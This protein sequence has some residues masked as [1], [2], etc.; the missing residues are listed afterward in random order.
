MEP[1]RSNSHEPA[2]AEP[3]QVARGD[4]KRFAV[5]LGGVVLLIAAVA[6]GI[7]LFGDRLPT[8]TEERLQ[9]AVRRWN[10]GDVDSY[11]MDLEITGQRAGKVHVEVQNGVVVELQ[12]DG[13]TPAQRRTWD[14]WSVPGQFDM[15]QQGL[16]IAVDPVGNL[17]AQQ[18]TQVVVR[19]T[20]DAQLGYPLAF[21]QV[22]LGGGPEFGWKTVRFERK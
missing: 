5:F 6:V 21:S 18:G 19:A 22:T 13:Q 1:D 4:W 17:Q 10:E 2:T 20:F 11:V 3:S 8:L 12:R 16:D 14:V 7:A 15:M 9:A